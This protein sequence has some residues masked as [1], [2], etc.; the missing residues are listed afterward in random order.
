M[1]WPRQSPRDSAGRRGARRFL[2]VAGWTLLALVVGI[3]LTMLYARQ[4][5]GAAPRI[6]R[7]RL[8][9]P[10]CGAAPFTIALFADLHL[11]GPTGADRVRDVVARVN[12][13]H[14]DAVLIAGDFFHGGEAISAA[15]ARSALAPLAGL[16]AREGVFAVLGNNDWQVGPQRVIDALAGSG[17]AVLGNDARIGRRMAVLGIEELTSGT[18]NPRLA[19]ERL[20][21]EQARTRRPLPSLVV[22]MAHNPVMFDRVPALPWL[23]VAGH[24]HGGQVLPELSIPA[25]RWLARHGG[26]T[27]RHGGWSSGRY[28]RGLYG[29]ADRRM[30][31]TSGVGTSTLP[32]R[33]GVPPEIVA[34]EFGGCRGGSGISAAR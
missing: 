14:P 2:R 9:A 28:V 21:A 4:E 1:T 15:E 6:V 31:V 26:D 34:I 11:S 29:A 30:I 27:T 8:P 20:A 23:M 16:S 13:L 18:A 19:L 5:A 7:Y 33:L 32:L 24:T 17:V 25:M 3:A 10:V 12:A 22:W